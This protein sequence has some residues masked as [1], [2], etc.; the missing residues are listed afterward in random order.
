MPAENLPLKDKPNLWDIPEQSDLSYTKIPI[1]G[2]NK[3]Q[4]KLY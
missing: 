3:F 2:D 1:F 4:K